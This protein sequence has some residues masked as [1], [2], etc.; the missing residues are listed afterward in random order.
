M[1]NRSPSTKERLK[2]GNEGAANS[3]QL[4]GEEARRGTEHGELTIVS[5]LSGSASCQE[6]NANDHNTFSCRTIDTLTSLYQI[7]TSAVA[8]LMS[9]NKKIPRFFARQTIKALVSTALLAYQRLAIRSRQ[10][11]RSSNTA[12]YLF[13]QRNCNTFV[14]SIRI[15]QAP[16]SPIVAP[17]RVAEGVCLAVG[18]TR[19]AVSVNTQ[20]KITQNASP[21]TRA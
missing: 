5:N 21:F 12:T 7:P 17:R 14:L 4:L 15:Q 6:S 20:N 3:A 16:L 9:F 11:P 1:Q 13:T 18:V 10:A 2:P 19:V 8:T